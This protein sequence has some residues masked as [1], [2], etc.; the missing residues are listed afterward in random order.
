MWK[1]LSPRTHKTASARN[2]LTG[3]RV[4]KHL[5]FATAVKLIILTVPLHF[6]EGFAPARLV[7]PEESVEL[8][9]SF[10]L[11]DHHGAPQTRESRPA[12]L[13]TYPTWACKLLII[14]RL[15]QLSVRVS[16][17]RRTTNA[18]C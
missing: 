10:R 17:C 11:G 3:S 6:R 2:S 15:Q 5:K 13:L 8:S 12:H 9:A 7:F 14:P 1:R 18:R 16:V 4:I